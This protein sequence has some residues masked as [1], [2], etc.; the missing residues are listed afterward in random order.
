MTTTCATTCAT[1][2]R[3][4][5]TWYLVDASQEVLGRMATRISRILQGKHKPTWTPHADTGDFVVVVNAEKVQLTGRKA[6]DKH[7]RYYTGNH[8][9]L[10]TV[11]FPKML[12]KHPDEII[13]TAVRRMLPKT[14]LGRHMLSKLKVFKG[15]THTHH[16]QDP[17][18]LALGTSRAA[19]A[20]VKAKNAATKA[21]KG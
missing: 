4:T 18:P 12:E 16:A 6:T 13:K 5:A 17:K 1:T 21:K 7:Y 3:D 9:G 8:G 11:M 10:V 20:G 19:R 2:R 14:D 15:P